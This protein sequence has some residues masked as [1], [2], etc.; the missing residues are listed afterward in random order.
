MY[1]LC[2]IYVFIQPVFMA[3]SVMMEIIV[4]FGRIVT[5]YIANGTIVLGVSIMVS[6]CTLI[7]FCFS[8]LVYQQSQPCKVI[9]QSVDKFLPVSSSYTF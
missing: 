3:T 7:N 2:I 8:L 6:T 1:L 9:T 5:T 4:T